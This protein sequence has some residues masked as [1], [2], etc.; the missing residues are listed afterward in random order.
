MRAPFEQ[1]SI[2]GWKARAGTLSVCLSV[3]ARWG[4]WMGPARVGPAGWTG[5][6]IVTPCGEHVP[7]L[8]KKL[9]LRAISCY[10]KQVARVVARSHCSRHQ[11]P[12][13]HLHLPLIMSGMMM[14]LRRAAE[15][16]RREEQRPDLP[17]PGSNGNELCSTARHGAEW[18]ARAVWPASAAQAAGWPR[19]GWP[20]LGARSG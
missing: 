11:P 8:L 20:E 16:V 3:D 14:R 7:Q 13:A 19:R 15:R 6:R 1:Q 18:K 4:N 9:L 17:P 12:A 2:G 5:P 10:E